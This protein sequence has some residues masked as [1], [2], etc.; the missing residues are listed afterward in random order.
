MTREELFMIKGVV[1]YKE[2]LY[3]HAI[4]VGVSR[5]WYA[6]PGHVS[7]IKRVLQRRLPAAVGHTIVESRVATDDPREDL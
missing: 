7:R 5:D 1:E 2:D 4:K 6:I 3:T